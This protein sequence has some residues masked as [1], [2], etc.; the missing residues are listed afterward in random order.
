MSSDKKRCIYTKNIDTSLLSPSGQSKPPAE[1]VV[2]TRRDAG[3]IKHLVD[4]DIIFPACRRYKK[5]QALIVRL[6]HI[7]SIQ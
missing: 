3:N 6:V 1:P 4:V 7:T 5:Y 2:L